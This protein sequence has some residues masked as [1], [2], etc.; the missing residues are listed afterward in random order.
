MAIFMGPSLLLSDVEPFP[1]IAVPMADWRVGM[2]VFDRAMS[3]YAS[4]FAD[5][6]I[7]VHMPLD[8]SLVRFFTFLDA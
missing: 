2:F 5:V 6:S 1:R 3:P 7:S 8:P 4:T